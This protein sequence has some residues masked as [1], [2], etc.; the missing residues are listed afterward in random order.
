MRRR[1]FLK[2]LVS[3]I[4]IRPNI[5]STTQSPSELSFYEPERDFGHRIRNP[6]W[7]KNG[8]ASS[9][10]HIVETDILIAG[11]G[12]GGLSCARVLEKHKQNFLIIEAAPFF[13]GTSA[14]ANFHNT[15][16]PLGAHYIMSPPDEAEDI[17]EFL[18]EA[19]I[20]TGFSGH[21]PKYNQN[22]VLEN[23]AR[24]DRSLYQGKW[25]EG[26]GEFLNAPSYRLRRFNQLMDFLSSFRGDDQKRW[27]SIPTSTS[28]RDSRAIEL[29]EISFEEYLR[30]TDLLDEEVRYVTEYACK[31]DY[32]A[33]IS[34][35][36]AWAGLHYFCCRP[37]SYKQFTLSTQSGNGHLVEHLLNSFNVQSRKSGT[38]LCSIQRQSDDWLCLLYSKEGFKTIRCKHLVY[39]GKS[40]ALSTLFSELPED[41][42]KLEKPLQQAPWLTTQVVMENLPDQLLETICWDNVS[43]TSRSVG[44]IY[45]N[46]FQTT[47]QKPILLTHFYPLLAIPKLTI[48][49]ISSLTESELAELVLED[50][51]A[52]NP[53]YLPYISQMI[54]RRLFHGMG[55]PKPG[56]VLPSLRSIDW[57]K[58][59]Y[60]AN[61]DAF[62]L[63]LFE[64]AFQAGVQC[65]R[66]I[67]K[68]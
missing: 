2:G 16:V 4:L 43:K 54:F 17:L 37:R 30:Q 31:D 12:I 56:F 53:E 36:S 58:G 48:K 47:I 14:S 33:P 10:H 25:H 20:I 62:G 38:L 64:E 68:G 6:D 65:A 44:Y 28:S 9:K 13:G 1:A 59:L 67:A 29:F 22:Y 60:L 24:R 18:E 3:S 5:F 40:H 7:I 61:S 50:L 39:A 32:G 11:G 34:K 52:M 19:K 57:P 21:I 51:G 41:L 66:E 8:W 23:D 45:S 35:V 26:I 15:P 42:K 63:P 55:I 49:K 46:Y 27:F